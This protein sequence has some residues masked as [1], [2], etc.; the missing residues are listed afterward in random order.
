MGHNPDI[1]SSIRVSINKALMPTE[2]RNKTQDRLTLTSINE[3]ATNL[4]GLFKCNKNVN[5]ASYFGM[6]TQQEK[7]DS[8]FSQL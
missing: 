1:A 4:Q 8:R 5:R 6:A 2:N 7:L 3:Y